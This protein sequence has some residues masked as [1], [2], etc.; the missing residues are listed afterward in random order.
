MQFRATCAKCNNVRM[1]CAE[2]RLCQE[3]HSVHAGGYVRPTGQSQA[4]CDLDTID[5]EHDQGLRD[6]TDPFE[7]NPGAPYG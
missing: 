4:H 3:H 5:L 1:V 2:C 6:L 7:H